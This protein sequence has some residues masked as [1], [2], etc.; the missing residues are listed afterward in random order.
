MGNMSRWR[1]GR[2]TVL[3]MEW[4][5]PAKRDI[6]HIASNG[7]LKVGKNGL[8]FVDTKDQNT[9]HTWDM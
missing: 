1:R 7:R 3:W 2:K 8:L 5:C 4:T 9:C 6:T